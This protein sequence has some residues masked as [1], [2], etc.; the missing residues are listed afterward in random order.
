MDIVPLQTDNGVNTTVTA[1]KNQEEMFSVAKGMGMAPE[2][3]SAHR[4]QA[5]MYVMGW[6][7]RPDAVIYSH[8]VCDSSPK[9]GEEL[10]HFYDIPGFYL[11]RP[12]SYREQDAEYY[13]QEMEQA[14][15]FLE[16]LSGRRMDWDRLLQ[17]LHFT[18]QVMELQKEVY[19]LRRASPS[20]MPNR[21]GPQ[22]M[23][24]GWL[25]GGSKEA[26]E[27]F[28]I[29]RD[30]LKARVARGKGFIPQEQFRLMCIFPPP[31]IEWKMLDW[32]EKE[33]GASIVADPFYF[34][35]GEWEIDL[36]RP[37]I[38]LARKCFASPVSR[39]LHGPALA[40]AVPDAVAD[41]LSHRAHG[42]IYWANVGCR[43]GCALIR[44]I[45]DALWKEVNIPTLVLDSDMLDPS[46]SPEAE[47]KDKL[48]GFLE[49]IQ[50]RR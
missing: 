14:I 11:D 44:S 46:V 30:E 41:A 45:K 3:C 18:W 23:N 27:Y 38:S 24:I 21:R 22:S 35:W 39:H 9:S 36:S 50:G 47:L 29:L 19:E 33:H 34:H 49:T 37:L 2:L 32:M 31:P 10:C 4:A 26:V 12:Y 42:A 8:Q 15:V 5:A 6:F 40:G 17:A 20:P 1:L 16:K 48:E 7:P 25:Y 28:T 13:A 43:H